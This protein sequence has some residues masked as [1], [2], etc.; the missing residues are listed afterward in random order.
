MT[1]KTIYSVR[2]GG[3]LF[4]LIV[5]FMLGALV[6]RAQTSGSLSGGVIFTADPTFADG[7]VTL[8]MLVRS[9]GLQRYDLL[10]ESNFAVDESADALQVSSEPT[11]PMT[12]IVM[13]NLSYASDVDLIRSTLRAYVESYYRPGDDV[14]FYIL[15]ANLLER[16]EPVDLA[17]LNSLIDGLSA[18]TLYA[19]IDGMVAAALDRVRAEL[20]ENPARAFQ[21]LLV[22]SYLRADDDPALARGFAA[23]NVPLHVIQAHRFRDDSTDKLRAFAQNGGGLFVNNLN[24]RFVQSGAP[25]SAVS[26]LQ[27]A[28]DAIESSRTIYTLTYRPLRRDLNTAPQVRLRVELDADQRISTDFTYPRTFAAPQL[29]LAD[30][31]LDL[32]RRPRYDEEQV[33]FDTSEARLNARVVFPDGVPRTLQ[34][35]RVEIVNAADG[36]VLQSELEFDP[37]ID[38]LGNF[39]LTWSLTAFDLPETT[40]PFRLVV[41]VTDSLGLT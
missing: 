9:A 2:F 3:V 18:S 17:G 31:S 25:I 5:C 21:T 30:D 7:Q 33:V 26:T 1:W 10:T 36:Q 13:V 38:P 34:S 23:L 12:L 40:T 29:E 41:T 4:S 27:L 22:G 19:P 35:L 28:Y 6:V 20:T 8:Q 15:G 37:T 39:N 16:V 11:A 14:I 24:G 32:R